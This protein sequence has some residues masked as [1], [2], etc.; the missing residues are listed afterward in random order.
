M[1]AAKRAWSLYKKKKAAFFTWPLS[2]AC[3]LSQCFVDSRT[4]P[5]LQRPKPQFPNFSIEIKL[6]RTFLLFFIP[7]FTPQSHYGQ[8]KN[9]SLSTFLYINLNYLMRKQ[10]T[11]SRFIIC[12]IILLTLVRN[13]DVLAIRTTN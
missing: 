11:I 12:R 7:K 5:P 9:L 10:P 13:L 3:L 4:S 6:T 1:I 8:Y 2:M